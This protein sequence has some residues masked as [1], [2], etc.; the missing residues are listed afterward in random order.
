M[1]RAGEVSVFAA[2][3]ILFVSY[4][5]G[6]PVAAEQQITVTQFVIDGANK[7]SALQIEQVKTAVVGRRGTSEEL[8]DTARRLL[9]GFLNSE[10]YIRPD[11]DLD[12]VNAY[13]S[14][15]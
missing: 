2:A 9:I 13:A 7:L 5:A 10:C 1:K 8:M 11:I 15:D 3:V 12:V 6:I 14:P 4:L